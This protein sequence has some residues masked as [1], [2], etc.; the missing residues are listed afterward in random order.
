MTSETAPR[1]PNSTRL[2]G[3]SRVTNIMT[4]DVEDWLESSLEL[5]PQDSPLR[6]SHVEPTQRVVVNTERLLAILDQAGVRATFFVLGTVADKYPTLVKHIHR[7]GHE[8]A[9][10]GYRHDLVYKM[11]RSEF[12]DSLQRCGTLLESL[13]GQRM[14]GYRAPYASITSQS[15]WALDV[16]QELGFEYDCS[17]FPIRR[18]LY[19]T[20]GAETYPHVIRQGASPLMEF[21]FS[22][23]RLFGTNIPIAGGGYF[24]LLPYAFTRWALRRINRQG[25]PAV[26]YLHPYELDT[27]ELRDPLQGEGWAGRKVRLSQRLNRGKTEGKLGRL[28]TDFEWTSVRGW[29]G[30]QKRSP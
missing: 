5:L 24:R 7:R 15:E 28:L 17:I 11:R 18:G 23:V 9:S 1:V 25:Q 8:I 26:F 3:V 29:I 27:E 6:R 10:H 19:G 16:L 20:P 22:T 13:T 30:N 14:R 4:V 12:T 2:S 21:P